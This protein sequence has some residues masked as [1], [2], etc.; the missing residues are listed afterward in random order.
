M[1]DR[2]N[3]Y[4]QAAM[5]NE[6]LEAACRKSATWLVERAEEETAGDAVSED[7]SASKAS[8]EERRQFRRRMWLAFA[9]QNRE[10]AERHARM[11]EKMER[12]L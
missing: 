1:A 2:Q 7:S 11:R 9:E 3:P 6:L 12:Y 5:R 8:S 10:E 4:F